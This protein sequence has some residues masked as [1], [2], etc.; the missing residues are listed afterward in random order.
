MDAPIPELNRLKEFQDSVGDWF[1]PGFELCPFGADDGGYPLAADRLGTF[2]L[3]TG[4]GA[5]YA[6]WLLD[7]G[8]EPAESPVVFLGDEG[9][10][11]LVARD[12][13]EFLR[14]LASGW[15]PWGSWERLMYFDER[16]E[17]GYAPCPANTEFRAWLRE[18]YGLEAVEDPNETVAA[19]EDALW[20]RFAAWVGP[21]YPDVVS[22]REKRP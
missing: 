9:G 17:E 4:S 12:V 3:A 21:L 22:A 8:I 5:A 14:V 2:A 10:I 18:N 6:V 16:D 15:T 20:D 19:T 7:E 1:A 13:R 11:N